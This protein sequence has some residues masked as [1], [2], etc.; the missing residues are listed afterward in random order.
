[1][2]N[3]ENKLT[4]FLQKLL[5]NKL[6]L[7]FASLA[8]PLGVG[9]LGAIF[10]A[11]AI[12][13][14]YQ[15]LN[16]P[17]FSPPNFVFA[18]VWTILYILMGISLYLIVIKKPTDEKSAKFFYSQLFLNLLW[19]Y[20]FFYARFTK[21]A[22]VE[23]IILA[24]FIFLTIKSFYKISKTAAYLLIPYFLWVLFASILNLSIVLLNPN[25]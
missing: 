23:I 1:M 22:F 7:L 10:T 6:F 5:K 15:A 21:T 8:L 16:K 18:P 25:L 2:K 9:F 3:L 14:W 4:A 19:S 12:P 11:P 20:L 24:V 13:T 17:A